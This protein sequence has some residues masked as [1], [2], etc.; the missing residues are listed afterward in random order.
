MPPLKGRKSQRQKAQLSC[1]CGKVG[2]I[3]FHCRIAVRGQLSAPFVVKGAVDG[4][5]FVTY[6][7]T[8]LLP[9][10]CKD[11]VVICDDLNVHNNKQAIE[12]IGAKG[13]WVLYLLASILLI[14]TP[15]KRPSQSVAPCCERQKPEPLMIYGKKS[16]ISVTSSLPKNAP[17]TSYLADIN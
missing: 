9:T 4:D 15:S 14:L 16:A 12:A 8:Q 7:Q 13:V 6:V 1:S 3:F 11:D 2:N 17:T 5:A 10:L